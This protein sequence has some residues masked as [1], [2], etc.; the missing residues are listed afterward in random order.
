MGQPSPAIRFKTTQHNDV[1]FLAGDQ[2]LSFSC[3]PQMEKK[4]GQLS[5]RFIL[6]GVAEF[7]EL[8]T[9]AMSAFSGI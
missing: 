5:S 1:C 2:L 8:S 9:V 4:F 3:V 6:V 7:L